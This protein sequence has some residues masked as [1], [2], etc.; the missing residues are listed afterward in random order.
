[1]LSAVFY[2]FGNMELEFSLDDWMRFMDY[3]L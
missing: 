2:L 3:E 1:M